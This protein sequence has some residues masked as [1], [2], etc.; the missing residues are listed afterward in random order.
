[1]APEAEDKEVFGLFDK[2]DLRSLGVVDKNGRPIG[3]IAV[4]DVV[5]RLVSRR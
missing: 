2:Y 4:D 1:V 3:V 5:T